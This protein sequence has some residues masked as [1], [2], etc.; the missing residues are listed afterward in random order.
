MAISYSDRRG[1]SDTDIV[2]ALLLANAVF[3][4]IIVLGWPALAD[5]LGPPIEW[6]MAAAGT[7]RMP[8]LDYPYTTLWLLPLAGCVLAMIGLRLGLAT[9]ASFAVWMP[10]MLLSMVLGWYY[11]APAAWH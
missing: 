2:L 10:P 7:A 8:L 6:A 5:I 1:R 9:L 11:L 3:V 4:V